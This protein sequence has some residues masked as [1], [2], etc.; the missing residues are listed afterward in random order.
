MVGGQHL[1]PT[2]PADHWVQDPKGGDSMMPEEIQCI[3]RLA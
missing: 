1:L 2:L 3:S